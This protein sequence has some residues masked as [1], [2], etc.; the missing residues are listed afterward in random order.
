M[1]K[2]KIFLPKTTFPM[3]AESSTEIDIISQWNEK[4]IQNKLREQSKDRPYFILHDGPPYANGNL[5]IGHA[6]N[7]ILKDVVN[8]SKQMTGYNA[9][10]IPGWDCHGLPIEW[11]IEEKYREKKKNKD[12]I[13]VIDFREEC[14]EYA[15]KWMQI[16][17][18]EFKR[19]GIEGDWDNRYA[20]LDYSTE[21]TIA[22]EICKFLMNG[23]LERGLRPVMWSP[24][25][26]TALAEAEIEYYNHT[27]TTI[28]VKFP[29]KTYTNQIF[30]KTSIVIW[31]TTPWTIP[32][33]RAIAAGPEIEYSLIETDNDEKYLVATLL[34]E[35][36]CKDISVTV[37]K[38]IDTFMGI[39]LKDMVCSH[40][41]NQFGYEQD[42]PVLMA[43]F[44]TTD[45]GTGFVH[46]APGH[47]IDDFKL[48]MEYGLD[49][50]ETVGPDGTF[51]SWV[52]LFAGKH[53]YKVAN[54]VIN[55]LGF[56]LLKKDTI[57]HSYPHSWRSKAPLIYRT[58]S[59]WFIR[60]DDT[61][62]IRENSLKAIDSIKF[63]PEQNSS[64][65]IK[66]MVTNRPDWCISRQRTWGVPIPVFVNKQTG[67][68]LRDSSVI[69][70][71]VNIFSKEGADAWY[72]S[73]A[74]RFLGDMYN[75]NDFEQIKDI[76]DIWFESGTSHAFVLEDRNLPQADLY[77]EGSDQHRGW[78]QSSMLESVGTRGVSPTKAI[79]TH[80]FVLDEKGRKMSKS[81]GNVT[82]PDDVIKTYGAD[83]LRLWV[84]M[85]DTSS[86]LRIGNNILK[87]QAEIYRKFRNTMRWILGC[88]DKFND[89]EKIPYSELPDLEKMILHRL[90]E[91]DEKIRKSVDSY[92]WNGVY[93][94]LYNF[95]SVDLSSFYFD[96]RKD[97][98]YCDSET[99]LK[100]RATRTVLD[101]LHRCLSVWLAP[102]L[103]FMAEESW[104]TRFD[105][106][107]H[108]QQFPVLPIEWKNDELNDKW[109][110]IQNIRHYF[111]SAVEMAKKENVIK[112]QSQ[113]YIEY[114]LPNILSDE[115]WT[116]ICLVSKTKI[117]EPYSSSIGPFN[118]YMAEGEKCQRCWNI[119][120]NVGMNNLCIR[121]DEIED[122]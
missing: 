65:R 4:N 19:L 120:T 93:S 28:W 116:E 9:H 44:V 50:P 17:K 112:S 83:V 72:S 35:K 104:T 66:S 53:V 13:S 67:K 41:L 79:M 92:D 51:N 24:V 39:E 22:K 91:F 36:F 107:V 87:Q 96:I 18:N 75:E 52:P 2:Y 97:T 68:L 6:L 12:D 42:A 71:I 1:S 25:E 106:S 88:L 73:P 84:M 95:C 77:L 40:P 61:N 57:V 46:I 101:Q 108:L 8:R 59:Q 117:I 23:S 56:S 45:V 119:S 115:E 15:K 3:R 37:Y 16:Q 20:T 49:I 69:D 110:D 118:V 81:E 7:K 11:K 113:A 14:R 109:K 64:N 33:N 80:G 114:C 99:N 70:R 58:T 30:D 43:D 122:Y 34:L 76:V 111:L 32:G 21:S 47:G 10:Y 98:L 94:F 102:V 86:D 85:S 89:N 5:H 74:S 63:V 55:A 60:M 105:D 121:C 31:T 38:I 48:G 54:D 29:I 78:F 90:T 62:K 100:R 27:S 103:C 82:S 26:K